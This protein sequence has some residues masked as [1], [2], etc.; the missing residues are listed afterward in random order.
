MEPVSLIKTPRKQNFNPVSM[1]SHNMITNN[2]PQQ[3]LDMLRPM[4]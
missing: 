3:E 1:P 2:P 4:M